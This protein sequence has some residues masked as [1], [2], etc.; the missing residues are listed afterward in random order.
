[1]LT[2]GILIDYVIYNLGVVVDTSVYIHPSCNRKQPAL[3]NFNAHA[4]L[5]TI[6]LL[7]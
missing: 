4:K 6:N 3:L 5:G 1:M 2:S 7:S